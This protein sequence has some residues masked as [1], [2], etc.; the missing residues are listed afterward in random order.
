[1]NIAIIGAGIAGL[2]ASVRLRLQGHEVSVF[3]AH[4]Q[5]GGKLIELREQGYRF[6]AGPSLFTL[7]QQVDE[8]FRLAGREPTAHFAYESLDVL[9]NYFFEDG[10]RIAAY[11]DQEAFAQEVAAKTEATP[12]QVHKF[13]RKSQSIYELTSHV[14][15]ERSLHRLQTYLKADTLKSIMQL[16]KLD[17]LRSMHQANASCFDDP[18]VVQLFDRYATYNGSNPYQAPATMNVIPH[19]EYSLGAYYPRGGM[20]SITRSI[21]ELARELGV[22]FVFNAKVDRIELTKDRKVRGVQVKG[23]FH[24]AGV[25]VS[26]MDV[27]PT[28]RHLLPDQPAPERILRQPRSSS[29]LIFYWGIA[30]TFPELD[31]HNI[32]FSQDYEGEFRQLWQDRSISDDPTVYI[33]ITSKR[34]PEDAPQG[35]ENWFVMI[36]VPSDT[37]QDWDEMIQRARSNIL[38]K[39][40]RLLGRD[41]KPLIACEQVLDPRII[42]SRTSSHQGALYGNSSNNRWAAFL[43]HPNFSR[44]IKGLYFCGGSVH[45]GGGIP[46][47]LLSA[48]ITGDVI[49]A[50]HPVS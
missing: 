1:M 19:L 13:L 26:N 9:C 43:R 16:Y 14:F 33:N 6:D 17:A 31:L 38:Q 20:Y 48:K 2:A 30:G 46:L 24:P 44:K 23:H 35:C 3:E 47:C 18:R 28:Y 15:M 21:Y 39:L 12:Q 7:P 42:A 36:N 22:T 32:F 8:L 5:P 41:I 37:G 4:D 49:A 25:V 10:C 40:S 50:N 27:V 11:S 45:P 29:A 34:S